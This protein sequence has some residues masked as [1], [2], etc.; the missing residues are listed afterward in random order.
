MKQKNHIFILILIVYSSIITYF[1]IAFSD[2]YDIVNTEGI[3]SLEVFYLLLIYRIMYKT[4]FYRHQYFSLLLLIAMGLSKYLIQ[5]FF[6]QNI[7]FNF[8]LLIQVLLYPL[9]ESIFYFFIEKYMKH[10]Y[11]SPFFINF[12]IGFIFTMIGII[13]LIIC[14]NI[15]FKD[16]EYYQV[17]FQKISVNYD[18]IILYIIYY[19][20]K[21][22][23]SFLQYKVIYEFSVFHFI[24]YSYIIEFAS[25][26]NSMIF[27]YDSRGF[28]LIAT[29]LIETFAILVFIEII[30]LN[31]CSFNVN[32]K[33]NIITRAGSEIQSIYKASEEDSSMDDSNSNLTNEQNENS[34]DN[35]SIY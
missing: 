21:A 25:I 8:F 15:D 32:L 16:N 26:I 3:T 1:Q 7:E 9:L 24:C 10:K 4:N 29:C 13:A 30:E 33:K 11:F 19:I 31:F 27:D 28:I 20:I 23:L 18:F 14:F 35:N 2:E 34:E 6:F 12:I 5:I 22:F 17:L